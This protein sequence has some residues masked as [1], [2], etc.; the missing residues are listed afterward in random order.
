MSKQTLSEF[1]VVRKDNGSDYAGPYSVRA[2][3]TTVVN[4]C[5]RHHVNRARIGAGTW[6]PHPD[7]LRVEERKYVYVETV[8]HLVKQKKGS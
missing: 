8:E 5:A 7:N 1:Y 4:R 6:M 3:A 2:P